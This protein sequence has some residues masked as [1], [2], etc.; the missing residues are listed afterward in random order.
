MTPHEAL[1]IFSCIGP[2]Q[3]NLGLCVVVILKALSWL[4]GVLCYHGYKPAPLWG[5]ALKEGSGS[6]SFQIF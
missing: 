3:N 1:I 2:K 4:S 5:G 6:C